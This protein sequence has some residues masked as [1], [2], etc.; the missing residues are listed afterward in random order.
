MPSLR[1]AVFAIAIAPLLLW[2]AGC[3]APSGDTGAPAPAPIAAPEAKPL[4]KDACANERALCTAQSKEASDKC[5]REK[6]A[7]C[8]N[9]CLI[10]NKFSLESCVTTYCDDKNQLNRD[11]WARLCST[12]R[13][14]RAKCAPAFEACVK[15]CP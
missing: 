12:E 13:K 7:Q 2:L 5:F 3:Q 9:T 11:N 10:G 6:K 1:N 15:T 8:L 14:S 4:C